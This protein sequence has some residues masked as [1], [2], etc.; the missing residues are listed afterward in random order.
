MRSVAWQYTQQPI[1]LYE[2]SAVFGMSGPKP[3]DDPSAMLEEV[4]GPSIWE[5]AVSTWIKTAVALMYMGS[6][7]WLPGLL[8]AHNKVPPSAWEYH[9]RKQ[10][11]HHGSHTHPTSYA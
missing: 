11:R 4:Y 10:V 6:N 5:S 1:F 9:I 2:S 3:S 7:A 8:Q